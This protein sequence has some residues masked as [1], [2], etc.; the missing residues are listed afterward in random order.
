MSVLCSVSERIHRNLPEEAHVPVTLLKNMNKSN[1][2]ESST[3]H[4]AKTLVTT[5]LTDL[6]V[7]LGFYG[8]QKRNR[9]N[10]AQ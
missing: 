10:G 5:I 2:L 6:H 4:F 3:S 8:E 1:Q 7:K 9:W